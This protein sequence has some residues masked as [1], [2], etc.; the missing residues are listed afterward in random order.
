MVSDI[1]EFPDEPYTGVGPDPRLADVN[2]GGPE[3]VDA[4]ET[5]DGEPLT[6]DPM[7]EIPDGMDPY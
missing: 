1:P 5:P 4:A 3:S 2:F 7:E 6:A